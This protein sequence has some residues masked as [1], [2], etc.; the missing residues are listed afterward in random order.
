MVNGQWLMVIINQPNKCHVGNCIKIKILA[1]CCNR[2]LSVFD[3]ETV[4][5]QNE[6]S[7]PEK[8]IQVSK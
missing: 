4:R 7:R 1:R 2:K 3:T 8:T 6:V 5:S